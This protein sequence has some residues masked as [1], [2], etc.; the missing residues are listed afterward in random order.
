MS[1]RGQLERATRNPRRDCA[2]GGAAIG[3]A[4]IVGFVRVAEPATQ[5]AGIG[6]AIEDH[7][8]VYRVVTAVRPG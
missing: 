5:V 7:G 1:R 4:F 3:D 8:D 2:S 6:D